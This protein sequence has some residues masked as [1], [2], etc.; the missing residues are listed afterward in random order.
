M[1]K[2]GRRG[3]QM[4]GTHYEFVVH[5]E[6][7]SNNSI[8]YKSSDVKWD[9][10]FPIPTII[11]KGV[12]QPMY[13]AVHILPPNWCKSGDVLQHWDIWLERNFM[14]GAIFNFYKAKRT[15]MKWL[16]YCRWQI[17][18]VVT[19]ITNICWNVTWNSK[20][21]HINYPRINFTV[22]SYHYMV[23]GVSCLTVIYLG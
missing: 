20:A 5:N 3:D 6:P 19:Y 15:F 10:D 14:F 1:Q 2:P 13:R 22:L 7:H 17:V 16:S 12:H 18:Y 11:W 9:T 21:I 8:I 23:L 4:E